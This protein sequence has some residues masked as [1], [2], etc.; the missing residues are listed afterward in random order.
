MDLAYPTLLWSNHNG[1]EKGDGV[2]DKVGTEIPNSW[3]NEATGLIEKPE[4]PVK[5]K[6]KKSDE[7]T[8]DALVE[9]N[10]G[11]PKKEKKTSD[12]DA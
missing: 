5:K 3:Y 2:D 8:E 9:Q 6:K 11:P 4:P 1:I 10:P 12:E 7:K